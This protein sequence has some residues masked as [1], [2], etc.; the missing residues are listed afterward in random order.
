MLLRQQT[1]SMD[2]AN[3]TTNIR[4]DSATKTGSVIDVIRLVNPESTSGHASVLFNRLT[5][6]D[7]ALTT[8]CCQLRINGKGKPTP[9]ADARTLVEIVWLLPGRA[10]RDFRRSSAASVCRMLGGDLSLVQEIEARYSSLHSTEAGR[11]AQ[12][13]LSQ[14]AVTA[15]VVNDKLPAE[16]QLATETQKEAFV[17]N[18]LRC[19]RLSD[20]DEIREKRIRILH[21]THE[22]MQ[23]LG[24]LDDRDKLEFKDRVRTILTADYETSNT[25][26]LVPSAH[27]DPGPSVPTPIC[28]SAVRGPETSMH[29]VASKLGVTVR[30]KAGQIGKLIKKKYAERYGS[31]AADNIP[32]RAVFFRG[33]PFLE[34]TYYE[35]DADLIQAAIQECLN[36]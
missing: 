7:S 30:D 14:S 28:V 29:I 23:A 16:L 12:E 13:F 35:R 11:A 17:E 15:E 4:V 9:C 34:N 18:W 5:T 19:K 21:S 20:A 36:P 25:N 27:V 33:K 26:A 8:R 10:A 6:E 1:L 3:F 2:V 32:K 22:L 31:K 24:G